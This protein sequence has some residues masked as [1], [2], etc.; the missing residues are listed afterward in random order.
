M[1][2]SSGI[3]LPI[4]SLPSPYGIGTFGKAAYD[5]ADF[6]KACGQKYWQ[7]LPLGPTSY[8][9]S[10]YQSFST[11]AGNPYFIDLDMLI[12][13]GLLTEE[14]VTAENWGSNPR[15]VDYGQVYSSRFK[16]LKLAKER[17][18]DK[19]RAE[20]EDF[21]NQ[22]P[23]LENYALFMALKNHFDQASWLQWDEDIRL[24]RPEALDRYRGELSE[25]IDFYVYIQYL[26]FKQWTKLKKYINDL[27][28]QIIGDLPIYV[29]LDSADVWSEPHFFKLDEKNYPVEV[30]GV[31]PDYFSEDGQL[32]GNPIYDWQAM[33]N[34]GYG[35]WIRRI[36]GA[37]K[38]YDMIRIDH[39]RGFDEYW[40]VPAGEK[41]AKNGQ[42]KKGPG[43]ELVGLLSNWFPNIKFIAED[44]GAPSP[45]VVQL[46]KDSGWP[47]M[48]VLSFA[49]DSGEPNDYQPHTYSP[50][51]ICY[52]GTHDNASIM[53]WY[54]DALEK[55]RD[56]ACKYLGIGKEEGFNWGIIR[57]GMSS[58]ANLFVAQLQDYLGLG[59]YNRINT[60]GT[61]SGNWQW[62]TLTE[63]LTEELAQKIHDMT[64]MY[65][66][67]S[68]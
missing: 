61:D 4:S 5:F 35:W 40:A 12:E 14:E 60:P 30:S 41:T 42:W 68:K 43:M 55:D 45:T 51:C 47:G 17:G 10:P 59:K 8:G 64:V 39:F 7:V 24:R 18:Y 62:R 32:W 52:S 25:D 56:Y 9:D 48:K 34:D 16:V 66:R 50:N 67:T 15:Y 38:L 29:A 36:D 49:F 31:P 63:E 33:K 20:I 3:L 54:E 2:R 22:N 27:G 28:I 44:L 26:F 1:E 11:Y 23:W 46:L 6:L 37:G 57:G 19:A 13:E 65:G 21:K 58:V 53:E